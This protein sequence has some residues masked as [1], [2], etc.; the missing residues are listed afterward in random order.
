MLFTKKK[1]GHT[2]IKERANAALASLQQNT[3]AMNVLRSRLE[4]RINSIFSIT[5]VIPRVTRS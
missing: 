4:S 5:K 1:N 3:Y 2:S